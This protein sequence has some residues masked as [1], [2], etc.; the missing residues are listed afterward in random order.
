MKREL[1]KDRQDL[2][3]A[4]LGDRT[5]KHPVRDTGARLPGREVIETLSWGWFEAA[6]G[7]AVILAFVLIGFLSV[8][9]WLG[10]LTALLT[11]MLD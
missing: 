6:L 2:L 5:G 3:D 9:G 8:H 7:A 11:P 4:W 1:S 10:P